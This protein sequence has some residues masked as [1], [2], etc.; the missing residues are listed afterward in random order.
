MFSPVSPQRSRIY[1]LTLLLLGQG[2]QIFHSIVIRQ[3]ARLVVNRKCGPAFPSS[4]RSA[5]CI[6]RKHNPVTTYLKSLSMPKN[7]SIKLT[8]ASALGLEDHHL[9]LE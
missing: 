9:S 3:D 7:G 8:C 4:F 6:I 1:T 2:C 5:S